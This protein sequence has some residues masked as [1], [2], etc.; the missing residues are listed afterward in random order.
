MPSCSAEGGGAGVDRLLRDLGRLLRRPKDVDELD[1]LWNLREDA[2]RSLAEDL[3][4]E[5]VDRNDAPTELLDACGH[6]VGWFSWR[7]ARTD[8]GDR[9]VRPQ[10]VF[11]DTVGASHGA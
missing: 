3:I 9:T 6:F 7:V 1:L 8:D 4:G 10:D 5:W 2:K 11:D